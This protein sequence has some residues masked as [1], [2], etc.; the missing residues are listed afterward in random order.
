MYG[1]LVDTTGV[2]IE[3]V[4]VQAFLRSSETN[5]PMPLFDTTDSIG[6]YRFQKVDL[7]GGAYT[8]EGDYNDSELVVRIDG[9]HYKDEQ[10]K[11][12]F[13]T[14]LPPGSI[15]GKVQLNSETESG[16]H[17]YIPGTSYDAWTDD[18]GGFTI[19]NIPQGN[20]MVKYTHPGYTTV[21]SWNIMVKSGK[22]TI[23][24]I[25]RLTYDPDY[26]ILPVPE[27]VNAQYDTLN[28]MVMLQ[29]ESVPL[30]DL[31]GYHVYRSYSPGDPAKLTSSAIPG[32]VFYHTLY[33][34]IP[35]TF[36][37]QIT[38]ITYQ[39][40]TI[41]SLNHESPFSSSV[42]VNAPSPS[43]LRTFFTWSIPSDRD[44]LIEGDSIRIVV[45]YTNRG[46]TIDTLRWYTGDPQ[47][48]IRTA[49]PKRTSG[50]DTLVYEWTKP[51]T[52]LLQVKAI[53][54]GGG[55]WHDS[56]SVDIFD[57]TVFR[58]H[59]E[60]I[61]CSSLA[62]ARRFVSTAILGSK[63]YVIGGCADLFTG[64]GKT[65]SALTSVEAY[66]F[67]SQQWTPQKDLQTA[68]YSAAAVETDGKLFVFGGLGYGDENT[69]L[70]EMFNPVTNNWSIIGEMPFYRYGHTACVVN[71]SIYIFGGMV[72]DTV[73]NTKRIAATIDV[74]DPVNKTW[75]TKSTPITP[76]SH[77]QTV[78][79]GN[80]VYIIGGFGGNESIPLAK[81]L[82][83][84]QIYSIT[85]GGVRDGV[86]MGQPRMNFGAAFMDS[87]LYVVGGVSS[88]SAPQLLGS[89]ERFDFPDNQW[90][91]CKS[92]PGG[93]R[94]CFGTEVYNKYL[95]VIGGSQK[96]NYLELGQ[97]DKVIRYSP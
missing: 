70:I 5:T 14:L 4:I 36:D 38:F 45:G 18:T 91:Q 43:W 61:A 86:T 49:S 82:A 53:D 68:R 83:T 56:M 48:E 11:I 52:Y 16:I 73:S 87:S 40:K 78:H 71:D 8:I 47:T 28:G 44:T 60:W 75:T 34:T 32:T 59:N 57:S 2:G 10:I 66:D 7:E 81:T 26:P 30:S 94:H 55:V 21:E 92:L 37:S 50:Y 29:W 95:Y 31:L 24:P 80:D 88:P 42:T 35:D 84:I 17:I 58:P 25:Q 19:S 85:D 74:F 9:I 46:R 1:K 93:G 13:D 63:L 3:G 67:S 22:N 90:H 79:M 6:V 76:R 65:P 62:I 64:S 51:G 96:A 77:H 15:S 12:G 97:T 20:Y 27:T 54:N 33:V 23:V 41:D 39:I 89:T 72:I 69:R